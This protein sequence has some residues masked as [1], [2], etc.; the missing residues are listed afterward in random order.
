[1]EL[2]LEPLSELEPLLEPP[3][4]ALLG[5]EP[6]LPE[7]DDGED[8]EDGAAEPPAAL[9]RLP[10]WSALEPVPALR[11]HAVMPTARTAAV[12]TAVMVFR[13]TLA[14]P[15]EVN[16]PPPS[17]SNGDAGSGRGNRDLR[18]KNYVL[19]TELGGGALGALALVFLEEALA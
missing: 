6:M 9:L 5:E 17:C 14:S 15:L 3:G 13:F 11:L 12:I 2:L 18:Y 7:G 4:L 1:L 19:S 16:G 8:G 10:Y